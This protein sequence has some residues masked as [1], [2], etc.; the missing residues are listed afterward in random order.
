MHTI[1]CCAFNILHPQM[2]TTRYSDDVWTSKLTSHSPEEVYNVVKFWLCEID[3][4]LMGDIAGPTQSDIQRWGEVLMQRPQHVL[5]DKAIELCISSYVYLSPEQIVD[6]IMFR[7]GDLMV[8]I[9]HSSTP[10]ERIHVGRYIRNRYL[11][12]YKNNP[13]TM[14]E[15]TPDIVDGCDVNP[16]HPDNLSDA[17]MQTI[18]QK[19]T[20]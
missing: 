12:W 16:K 13:H 15:Y 4:E 1:D 11:L 6:D 3:T 2:T 10:S 19:A 14:L 18:K 5:I 7:G 20:D 9:C 8:C 17:I